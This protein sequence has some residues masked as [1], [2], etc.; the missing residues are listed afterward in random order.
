M[1]NEDWINLDRKAI[2]TIRQCLAKN[3]YFHVVREKTV[4]YLWHKLHDLYEKNT[5]SNKVLL[6]K[7]L[8]N[9]KMKEGALVAQH[10]NE[11]NIITTHL[12]VILLM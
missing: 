8:Y 4:E 10:L 3:F 1:K 5:T 2:S 12:Y 9:L 7:K 11:F 6:I